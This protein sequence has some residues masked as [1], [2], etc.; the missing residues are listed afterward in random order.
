MID[1]DHYQ[2]GIV[3]IRTVSSWGGGS[4]SFMIELSNETKECIDI[5]FSKELRKRVGDLLR[6]ECG[7]NL[8]FCENQDEQGM[9]RIRFAVLRLSHGDMDELG[10]A[11]HLAKTDWRDLLVAGGLEKDPEAHKKWR[12]I[13]SSR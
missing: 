1:A 2:R 10:E 8:P 9:E 11:I 12:I 13:I 3:G 4:T 5:M 7:N 6:E